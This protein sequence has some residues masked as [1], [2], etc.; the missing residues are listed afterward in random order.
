MPGPLRWLFLDMDNYFA[1]VEQQDRP[2]LR[3][4]PV[5]VI[6]CESM[7]TCCIAAS[8]EAKAHGVKT[9]TGVREAK[10]LCPGIELVV[11]R[12]KRYVEVHKQIYA[13]IT[14]V[15]PIDKVWSIDEVAVRLLG[16][17]CEVEQAMD[18]GRRV[19]RAVCPGVGEALSCSVGLA[20]SRLVAKIAS[21]LGKPDGLTA[22]AP[23]DLPGK[24]AHLSLVDLPGI[25]VGIRARLH[26]HDILTVE[27]LWAMTAQQAQ[28]AWGSVE[29]R[30]YWMGL[31]G[32]EPKVH[33]E[34]RRM[35]T[36]A[37]VLAPELRTPAGAH[38][39][40]TRLLHK[41]AG[42]LRAHGYFAGSL[43]ASVTDASGTRWRDGIDLPTCQ[44]T[45]TVIEHFERLWRRRPAHAMP[46]P[47]KVGITLG[48]LTPTQST[49]GL[50][51]DEPNTRNAL[52]HAIDAIN[53]RFGGHAVYMGGMHEVAKLDMPDKIAFGRIP[54]EKVAM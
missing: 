38:A 39:V 10:Q 31:H 1:S 21:E 14:N 49:T 25:N 12:P 41:A 48:G 5:G 29:G 22:L 19:K 32:Q 11:A 47:K 20:H 33:A 26:K 42:R 8:K 6:P 36:H 53:E 16:R 44:D 34:H 37:N 28:E 18:I 13:A 4:R 7:G 40:M 9:G 54:D 27:D 17:E 2:G 35:F 30:R 43:S 15:V 51:F 23:D 52:G 50:L 45:I 3:G 24:I 46:V